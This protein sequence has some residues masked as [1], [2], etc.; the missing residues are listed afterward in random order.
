VAQLAQLAEWCSGAVAPGARSGAWHRLPADR[1]RSL[2]LPLQRETGQGV[3]WLKEVLSGVADFQKKGAHV[4]TFELR[5]E[6][7]GKQ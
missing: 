2:R 6:Y 5:P 1:S 7:R 4:G 3:T